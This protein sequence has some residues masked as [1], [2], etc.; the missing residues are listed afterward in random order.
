MI[1]GVGF[2][3]VKELNNGLNGQLL[4]VVKKVEYPGMYYFFVEINIKNIIA[5]YDSFKYF[6]L[7]NN[8]MLV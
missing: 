1:V 6:V 2:V 5:F 7:C 8:R 3:S 4:K